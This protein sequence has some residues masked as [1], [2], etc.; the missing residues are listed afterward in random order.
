MTL[1]TNATQLD[2]RQLQ[3]KSG[4]SPASWTITPSAATGGTFTAS[5]YSITYDT[6]TQTITP[7]A[8]T[9]SGM[10]AASKTYDTTTTA[11]VNNSGDSLSGIVVGLNNGGGTSDVVTLGGT[12]NTSGTFS[13]ANA[14]TWTVTGSGL[15][16]SG[17]DAGN[18]TFGQPTATATI[19]DL[20]PP[21]V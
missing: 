12:G 15:T 16:I 6:G 13:S 2:Q 7:A 3:G 4:S 17:A 14:G 11:V 1:S 9:I 20:P 10:T 18:Y 21:A 19:T 8:L 5:N